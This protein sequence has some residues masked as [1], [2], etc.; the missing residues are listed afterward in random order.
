MSRVLVSKRR[1]DA[2]RGKEPLNL[3]HPDSCQSDL[4]H[5]ARGQVWSKYGYFNPCD[6][7]PSQWCKPQHNRCL[8]LPGTRTLVEWERWVKLL[9]EVV[10]VVRSGVRLAGGG[11]GAPERHEAQSR[12]GPLRPARAAVTAGGTQPHVEVSVPPLRHAL[13]ARLLG[14]TPS[15]TCYCGCC[16]S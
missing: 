15:G 2:R 12:G 1:I 5:G 7:H 10:A 9:I 16:V 8:P 11:A 13:P 4:D 14:P 3:G 6:G